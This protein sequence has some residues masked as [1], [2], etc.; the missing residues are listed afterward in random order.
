MM[1]IWEL[2]PRAIRRCDY[3]AGATKWWSGGRRLSVALQQL[4]LV[5][6][7]LCFS[8]TRSGACLACS[9][10][11]CDAGAALENQSFIELDLWQAFQAHQVGTILTLSEETRLIYLVAANV[12]WRREE[13]D[14]TAEWW[15]TANGTYESVPRNV[16]A[17]ESVEL[18]RLD[19]LRLH[20]LDS[21]AIGDIQSTSLEFIA[22]SQSTSD[23]CSCAHHTLSFATPSDHTPIHL[24]ADIEFLPS[25]F[26]SISSLLSFSTSSAALGQAARSP[27]DNATTG[28]GQPKIASSGAPAEL[29]L[30]DI[31]HFGIAVTSVSASTGSWQAAY[32]GSENTD[33]FLEPGEQQPPVLLGPDTLIG[34]VASL[35][36]EFECTGEAPSVSFVPWQ[37]GHDADLQQAPGVI[38]IRPVDLG[39]VSE[40]P[41]SSAPVANIANTALQP[42]TQPAVANSGTQYAASPDPVSSVAGAARI[43]PLTT[44]AVP[45][46]HPTSSPTSEEIPMPGHALTAPLH[47]TPTRIHVPVPAITVTSNPTIAGQVTV[48]PKQGVLAEDTH[49][50]PAQTGKSRPMVRPTQAEQTTVQQPV[51]TQAQGTSGHTDPMTGVPAAHT[52]ATENPPTAQSELMSARITSSPV[53]AAV[54]EPVKSK[55]PATT[56]PPPTSSERGQPAYHCS[57]PPTSNLPGCALADGLLVPSALTAT[58]SI[59]IIL[60]GQ[61]TAAIRTY[62]SG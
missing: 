16:T 25:T 47:E 7:V 52:L 53:R 48:D 57:R 12:S 59:A 15:F 39:C 28:P 37:L 61:F 2:L 26:S 55:S 46:S 49:S 3:K 36:V 19:W 34:F 20:F 41:A 8:Q 9:L 18:G 27:G 38:H 21:S 1:V 60:P 40:E 62:W 45:E 29:T 31:E 56:D 58:P 11:D 54:P 17:A 51:R 23:N 35:H 13:N 14:G 24:A 6:V 5:L 32:A 4:V 30:F 44:T 50:T 43:Q 42:L 10:G 33:V 22:V